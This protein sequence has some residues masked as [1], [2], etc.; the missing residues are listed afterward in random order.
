MIGYKDLIM[1]IKIDTNLFSSNISIVNP[2]TDK[3]TLEY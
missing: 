1:P 3:I 2:L